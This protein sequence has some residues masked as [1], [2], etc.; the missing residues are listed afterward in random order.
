M[1]VEQAV[2]TLMLPLR[3]EIYRWGLSLFCHQYFNDKV[4]LTF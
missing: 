1:E 4:L 2:T 3:G